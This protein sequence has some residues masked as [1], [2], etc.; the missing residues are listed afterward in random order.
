MVPFMIAGAGI[1]IAS[2]MM[3]ARSRAKAERAAIRAKRKS[4][5]LKFSSTESSVNIMKATALESSYNA[6]H[7]VL[8]EGAARSRETKEVIDEA[9]STTVARS[10]GLTSGRS[11]G[12]Q[13]VE[14]YVKGNKALD[15]VDAQSRSMVN[16]IVD[17]QDK[18]TN[19]LNNKLL[20]AHQDLS[21]VLADEGG[22]TTYTGMDALRAGLSGA[23]QGYSLGKAYKSL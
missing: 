15:K 4:A 16:Q 17:E 20:S 22:G 7:E 18:I 2:S 19:D 12:R 8:R 10:E 5:R 6:T 14:V 13:L 11:Q 3:G 21:A 1:S 23:Q 9:A